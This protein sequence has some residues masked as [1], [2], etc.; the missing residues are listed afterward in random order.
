MSQTGT[1]A[2]PGWLGSGIAALGKAVAWLSLLLVLI[3]FCVVVLRYGFN[4][5]WIWLQE[6]VTY[7]HA[8]IFMLAAAWTWQ[9]DEHVRVDI[10][11]REMTPRHKAIVNLAGTLVFLVPFCIFLLVVSWRYVS[12]AW[13]TMEGSREAG[14]LPFVYLQKSLILLLPA[15]LLLQ[16]VEVI[17]GNVRTLFPKADPK[18]T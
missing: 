12:L 16:A 17:R 13:I 5:G 8:M 3:S 9:I 14:G 11:Y 15:L 18:P 4:L 7:L 1:E 6:S 2:S 10:F